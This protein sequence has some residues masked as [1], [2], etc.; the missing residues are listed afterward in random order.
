MPRGVV[1]AKLGASR[2]TQS[3]M[4]GCRA[5]APTLLGQPPK[6]HSASGLVFIYLSVG[7]HAP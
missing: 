1:A 3:R 4:F 6:V 5:Q 7:L 2:M